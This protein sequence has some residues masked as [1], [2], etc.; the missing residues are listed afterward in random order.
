MWHASVEWVDRNRGRCRVVTEASTATREIMATVAK[1]LLA[2]V[3]CLPS[4]LELGGYCLHYRKSIT[5][6]EEASLD[7]AWRVIPPDSLAGRGV[8]LEK[9]EIRCAT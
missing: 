3:G 6:Q 5:E 9:D 4:T 2:G 7:P 8:I 1:E